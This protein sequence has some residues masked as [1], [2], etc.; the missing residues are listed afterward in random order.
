[1]VGCETIVYPEITNHAFQCLLLQIMQSL[2]M[3]CGRALSMLRFF[4]I[5]GAMVDSEDEGELMFPLVQG[6]SDSFGSSLIDQS[7]L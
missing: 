2:M 6:S 3:E 7:S 5:E 4:T 1:M